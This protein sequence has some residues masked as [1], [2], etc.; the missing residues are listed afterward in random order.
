MLSATVELT[1]AQIKTLPD[2]PVVIVP[3]TETLNYSGVPTSIPLPLFAVVS[4]NTIAGEYTN[5]GA[6]PH[7]TLVLGSDWSA[8]AMKVKYTSPTDAV[9]YY[10]SNTQYTTTAAVPDDPHSH[11]LSPLNLIL[12]GGL[13]D[14][15][16]A[17]VFDNGDGTDL[18][19]GNAANSMKVTV[20]YVL[21]DL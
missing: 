8:D 4:V 20:F 3:A 10:L 15:A 14:N 2:T 5:T 9:V 1:D 18:T 17:I 6:D 16:L 11:E 7:L 19:G 13:Y 12:N 21:V